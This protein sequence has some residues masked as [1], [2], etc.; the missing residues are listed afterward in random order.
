MA[1]LIDEEW[2]E[3]LVGIRMS[4]P[5]NWWPG[6]N[7][8]ELYLGRISSLDLDADGARYFQL[9]L[10]DEPGVYYPMRYDAVLHY[11]DEGQRKY[12]SY[13]LPNSVPANPVSE[14]VRVPGRNR[15]GPRVIA[16]TNDNDNDSFMATSEEE[17]SESE[18]EVSGEDDEEVDNTTYKLTNPAD[19]K[20]IGGRNTGRDVDP[21]PFEGENELFIFHLK[22]NSLLMN[23]FSGDNEL[24]TVNISEEELEGLKDSNGD[25]RF[26]QVFEWLLPTYGEE[27]DEDSF[28]DFLAARMRNYMIHIMRTQKHSALIV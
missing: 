25:I 22:M 24:F 8:N 14:T 2:A 19:W 7:G 6:Y 11:A 23:S 15:R 4:I 18:S 3:T 21:I 20:K 28:W 9:E 12:L 16:R 17:S 26:P 13:H 10:D 1:P 5:E 27:G